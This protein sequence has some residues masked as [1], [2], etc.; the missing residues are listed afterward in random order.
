MKNKNTETYR[1]TDSTPTNPAVCPNMHTVN[2]TLPPLLIYIIHIICM[3][4]N[5]RYTHH[6]IYDGKIHLSVHS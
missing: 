1:L 5:T 2:Y 3:H 4:S 6:A